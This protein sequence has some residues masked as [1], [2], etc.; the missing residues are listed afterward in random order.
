MIGWQIVNALTTDPRA[1]YV[2][3]GIIPRDHLE[4]TIVHTRHPS[5]YIIN[6]D[7]H[8]EPGSHWVACYFS[9]SGGE[10]EY[11]DPYGLPPSHPEIEHFIKKNSRRYRFSRRVIQSPLS[12]T[13]GIYCVYYV[14][15]KA[16]GYSLERALLPFHPYKLYH[17]DRHILSWMRTDQTT[18][19]HVTRH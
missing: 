16:R 3:K 8:D 5:A 4:D 14:K 19:S 9:S 15:K 10:A 17:N 11:F 2:F 18:P 12:K 13:C 6:L 1:K 7:R